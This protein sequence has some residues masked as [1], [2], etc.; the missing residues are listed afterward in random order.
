MHNSKDNEAHP[1]DEKELEALEEEMS[2]T[3]SAYLTRVPQR[4]ETQN[5]IRSLQSEF[6]VLPQ[7]R[8][9]D[10]EMLE[11]LP[12]QRLSFFRQCWIQ[13]QLFGKAF[14]A[15]SA[16]VIIMLTLISPVSE[17]LL[18]GFRDLYSLVLPLFLL[19]AA[20]YSYKS[21]NGEMRMVE[22]IT[23]FPPALLLLSR[24]L[25]I[26]AMIVLFGFIT[27]CFLVWTHYTFDAGSFLLGWMSGVLFVGG[28]LAYITYHRGIRIGFAAAGASWALLQIGGGLLER[29]FTEKQE[30]LHWFQAAVLLMGV[31]LFFRALRAGLGS[32]WAKYI[33]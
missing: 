14:W 3:L 22:S 7:Q 30:V 11:P 1:V 12:L 24:L 6:A 18:W 29:F 17:T 33:D 8:E 5:L 10:L 9:P 20:L 23:P 31:L 26:T 16:L 15:I 21:W 13:L 27:S 19:C 4:E 28:I 2:R 32:G 25:L